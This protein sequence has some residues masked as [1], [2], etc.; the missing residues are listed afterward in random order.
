ML[1]FTPEEIFPRHSRVI[2]ERNVRS[3]NV[4]RSENKHR[5]AFSRTLLD[6]GLSLSL[7]LSML[8]RSN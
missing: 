4:I 1:N 2:E 8:E 5:I 7:S 6:A 3:I